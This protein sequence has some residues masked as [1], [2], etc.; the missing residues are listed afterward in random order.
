LLRFA[1]NDDAISKNKSIANML[2]KTMVFPQSGGKKYGGKTKIGKA[3]IMQNMV[4]Y[5]QR[6]PLLI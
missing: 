5:I 1:R 2:L 4:L 6:K 3:K